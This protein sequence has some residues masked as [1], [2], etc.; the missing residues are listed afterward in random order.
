[1]WARRI[2]GREKHEAD[3][4]SHAPTLERTW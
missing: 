2:A 4:V 3:K 1:V